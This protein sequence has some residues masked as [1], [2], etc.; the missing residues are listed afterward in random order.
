MSCEESEKKEMNIFEKILA[1]ASKKKNVTQG[2]IVE[3]EIDKAMINDITGPLAAEAFEKMGGQ[4]L[5]DKERVIAINDHYVPASTI[6]SAEVHK[7]MRNFAQKYGVTNFYDVG[8]GGICHQVMVEKS[9]VLPGELV[10]GADSHTTTYG[11]VGAFSAGIG[12]TEMGAVFLT[13]KLWFKVPEATNIVVHRKLEFMV[14]PKDVILYIIGQL[15]ADGATYMG[16]KF[17]GEA[18]DD[19]SIDGR[20]TLCNMAVEMGAK[21]GIVEPDNKTIEY[22]KSRSDKS[23]NV[24]NDDS[25]SVYARTIDYNASEIVPLVACPFT[26]DNVKP[27]SDLEGTEIDQAF[28]G[29]CTNG[30]MEDLR[31]AERIMRG[32]KVKEG[33]RAIVV[34]ASQEVYLTALKEGILKSFVKSEVT[35]ANPN[36]GPCFGGHMGILTE[37]E[38]CVSTSNR[39][40]VG[41]MGSPKSKVYLASPA[42]VAASAIMGR[43]TDPRHLEA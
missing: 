30:R 17:S 4:Q 13:G 7:A 34:P 18:I 31:L 42:T 36:C 35:V 40:F 10:V 3:A 15:G 5:W 11:A 21:A 37:G 23:F 19:M 20:M 32:R 33:V 25:S 26:V 22:L 6:Q 41:R 38:S 1:R 28:I 24:V 8:R 2:E 12:S 9:H 39:N 29:A 16:V 27:V 14:T 43:I